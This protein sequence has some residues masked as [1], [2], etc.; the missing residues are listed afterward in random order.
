[1][2]RF[3]RYTVIGAEDVMLSLAN[4]M[5]CGTDSIQVGMGVRAN[6]SDGFGQQGDSEVMAEYSKVKGDV[7][8]WTYCHFINAGYI[9]RMWSNFTVP[10]P[11]DI[12]LPR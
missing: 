1:M 5:E 11:H 10:N 4:N 6:H 12:R 3:R 2:Y 9:P 7:L 8:E